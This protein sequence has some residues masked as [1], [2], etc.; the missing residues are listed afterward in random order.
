[1]PR[2][3]GHR[4]SLLL[5][6]FPAGMLRNASFESSCF[7]WNQVT[8]NFYSFFFTE[9]SFYTDRCSISDDFGWIVTETHCQRYDWCVRRLQLMNSNAKLANQFCLPFGF[10][11]RWS[12][13]HSE[14]STG[15]PEGTWFNIL[16]ADLGQ[17]DRL[18]REQEARFWLQ[19]QVFILRFF[20][21]KG[22]GLLLLPPRAHKVN[23][24]NSHNG[25]RHGKIKCQRI[26]R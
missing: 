12:I 20:R 8:D 5:P 11:G 6:W 16:Q 3:V 24:Y 7:C 26:E 19:Y 2:E 10:A 25:S 4:R 22:P 21:I 13:H 1:M 17:A 18:N 15:F 9:R 14:D 23:S